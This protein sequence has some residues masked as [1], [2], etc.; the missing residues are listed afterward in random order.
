MQNLTTEIFDKGI[1]NFVTD[2][3]SPQSASIDALGWVSTDDVIETIRGRLLFGGEDGNVDISQ[4][5]KGSTVA[6][7]QTDSVSSNVKIAQ[8]FKPSKTILS[9]LSLWKFSDTGVFSGTV[10]IS[11]QSDSSNVPDGVNLVAKTYSN[12]DWLSLPIGHFDFYFSNK[13]TLDTTKTY[14]IVI[15]TSTSDTSN[16]INLNYKDS[17]AYSN[18][19]L[20]FNNTSNGWVDLATSDLYFR[21][22]TDPYGSSTGLHFGYKS[23]GTLVVL[24]KAGTTIQWFNGTYWLD[25]ITG[26]EVEEIYAFSNYTSL[27]GNFIYVGGKSALYKVVC[28]NPTDAINMY[29]EDRN[30]KG[31]IRIDRGRMFLWD[32]AEDKTGLYGSKIDPQSGSV[33][34]TETSEVLGSSGSTTYSG[35]LAFKSGNSRATCFGILITTTIDGSAV[36]VTDDFNGNL[37]L[38]GDIIGTINYATG[39]YTITFSS[40]TEA[41]VEAEYQWEDSTNGGVADF[42]KSATRVAGEGFIFRQDEGGDKIQKVLIQ[43]GKYYSIK[44]KSVYEVNISADD[45][46]ATN[47]P[48]RLNIGIPSYN[49]AIETSIGI[50]FMNTANPDKPILTTLQKNTTGSELEPIILCPQFN[51]SDYVWDEMAM[52]TYGEY[53]VFS[54]KTKESDKNNRLFLFNN[55]LNIIDIARF[56]VNNFTKDSGV[57][58]AGSSVNFSISKILTGFDDDGSEPENYWIGRGELFSTQILK[59]IKKFQIKG[60]IS[61]L[62]QLEV[63]ISEDDEPFRLIGTV[64]GDADYVDFANSSTIGSSGIGVNSIGGNYGIQIFP[65]HTEFKFTSQP[66]FRK[67]NIK[68]IK[69]GIGY[70]SVQKFTDYDIR[71]FDDKLPKKYRIKQDISLDGTLTDQ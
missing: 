31:K 43:D 37:K 28:A 32:R 15:T 54:G 11:I 50:V 51:F 61:R 5:L 21:T 42:R 2:E 53:V 9:G 36:T 22:L 33:Y 52:E 41:N 60:K 45:S 7:G 67:R 70:T 29:V 10:T 17:N 63:Y 19:K 48:Y 18:G 34:T 40:V 26:L 65:Y 62:C 38:S 27:A 3:S 16:C 24:R 44:E 49:G 68:F 23:D 6:V 58:Y 46:S 56:N 1:Y 47:L 66:K 12:E 64:R 71:F 69:R 57:L 20:M 4:N 39:E 14:W 25:I 30:F 59:K 8:S 55:R 13:I 35:M